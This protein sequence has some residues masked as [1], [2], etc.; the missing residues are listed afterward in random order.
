VSLLAEAANRDAIRRSVPRVQAREP[1]LR[2]VDWR[3]L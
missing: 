1:L 2:L 3:L